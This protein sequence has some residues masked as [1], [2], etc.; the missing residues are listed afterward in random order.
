MSII[1]RVDIV[2]SPS[3]APVLTFNKN[4]Y[5][6]KLV[7]AAII[8]AFSLAENSKEGVIGTMLISPLGTPIV[9]MVTSLMAFNIPEFIVN[10]IIVVVSSLF[11]IGSGVGVGQIY[12]DYEPTDEMVQRYGTLSFKN[13]I[14]AFFIGIILSMGSLSIGKS[15]GFGPSELVGAGIAISLLPPLVNAGL[16]HV[17]V[18]LEDEKRTRCVMNSLKLAIYNMIGLSIGAIVA[19]ITWMLMRESIAL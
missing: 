1:R 14:I 10:A 18:K 12:K 4:W 19:F 17:N 5:V 8:A 15:D 2:L 7:L 16:T 3:K 6:L 13:I 9:A 11:L